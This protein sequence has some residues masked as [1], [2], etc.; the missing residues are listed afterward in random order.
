MFF[1]RNENFNSKGVLLWYRAYLRAESKVPMAHSD[2]KKQPL[3]YISL[4]PGQP[5]EKVRKCKYKN[6]I[7]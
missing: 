1:S 5:L 6:S 7:L 2:L 3:H 4:L